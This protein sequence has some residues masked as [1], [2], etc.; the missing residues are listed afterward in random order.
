MATTDNTLPNDDYD[1]PWKS[2]LDRYFQDFM[3]FFFPTAH[4]DIDWA[5]G[6]ENLDT[7]LQQIVR[8]AEL[9]KRLADKLC[10]VK[11]RSGETVMVLIHIEVQG[12]YD[13]GFSKRMY[14]YNYRLFDRYDQ[15]VVSFAVLSD[16]R[17]QW[18][19][20]SYEQVL[21]G[22]R[23]GITFP[24]V[25]LLDYIPRWDELEQSRN[26]FS[27]A[28]MAH[29]QTRATKSE[30]QQRLHWKLRL[31]KH[32]YARGY[33]REDVLELFRIIDWLL[34]LPVELEQQ[35]H[36][37]I[38]DY[39]AQMSTPYVTSVERL[40]FQ[41]GLQQGIEQGETKERQRALQTERALLLRLAKAYFGEID[42]DNFASLLE[43]IDQHEHLT[44]VGEWIDQCTSAEELISRVQQLVSEQQH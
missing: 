28:V 21:W 14:T 24:T 44:A 12:Q 8:D 7:E 36:H 26:P 42:I 22:C 32:L 5:S 17:P 30:P 25:K 19:P 33:Q 3:A 27:V 9:G 37:E 41:R 10:K 4:A 34:R 11:R 31:V 20:D 35:F 15:P 2:L 13:A 18:R 39:E 1:S 29:L 38:A 6:Y 16:D 40:G 43:H 23:T